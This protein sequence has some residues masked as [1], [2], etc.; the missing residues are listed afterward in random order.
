[1]TLN[2]ILPEELLARYIFDK[3]Y[4]RSSDSTVRPNAFMPAPDNK[5]SVFQINSLKEN[6]VWNI[7]QEVASQR[8]KTLLGRADILAKQVF[9]KKLGIESAKPPP[10]HANIIWP[11]EKSEQK[12]IAMELAALA[13]LHLL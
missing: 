10:H 9:D 6:K 1:M 7:G 5:T 8:K 3:S 11:L 4:Y 13:K 12:M 2:S